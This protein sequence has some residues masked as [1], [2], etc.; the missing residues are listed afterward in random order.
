MTNVMI[1]NVFDMHLTLF[2]GITNQKYNLKK[3]LP[4]LVVGPSSI[5]YSELG[6]QL[7]EKKKREKKIAVGLKPFSFYSYFLHDCGAA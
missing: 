3:E 4:I 6:D 1:K 7:K 2:I 5:M